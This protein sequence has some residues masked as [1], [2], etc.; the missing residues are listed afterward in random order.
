MP[1]SFSSHRLAWDQIGDDDQLFIQSDDH[2]LSSSNPR[3]RPMPSAN[4]HSSDHEFPHS[5]QPPPKRKRTTVASYQSLP[6]DGY[7]DHTFAPR[8]PSSS[9]EHVGASNDSRANPSSSN[10]KLP[11][12]GPKN[13]P[14]KPWKYD[15]EGCA[16][17]R[18]HQSTCWWKKNRPIGNPNGAESWEEEKLCNSMSSDGI[19]PS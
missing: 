11:S 13:A 18:T 12:Q 19:L 5:V 2:L 3:H 9:F 15:A 8:Q 1:A 4:F 7:L 10:H 17:C 14:S 6:N 16:N